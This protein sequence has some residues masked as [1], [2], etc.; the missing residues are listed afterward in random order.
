MWKY[1]STH[2]LPFWNDTSIVF[3]LNEN[4][5]ILIKISLNSVPN[6]PVKNKQAPNMQ[7]AI[8]WT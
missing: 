4:H 3:S 2:W 5:D 1:I 8:T 6:G 7:H